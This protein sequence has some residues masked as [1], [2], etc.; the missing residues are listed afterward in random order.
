[1]LHS[2]I[3]PSIR[4]RVMDG[5]EGC[6]PAAMPPR[7]LANLAIAASRNLPIVAP[8]EGDGA[9]VAGY[10]FPAPRSSGAGTILAARCVPTL[11][12]RERTVAGTGPSGYSQ[13]HACVRWADGG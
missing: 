3:R 8:C 5:E 10:S 12:G 1:M 6:Y 13:P 7:R 9:G 4:P 11:A 2:L